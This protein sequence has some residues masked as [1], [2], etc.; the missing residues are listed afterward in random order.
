[1]SLVNALVKQASKLMNKPKEEGAL[2]SSVKERAETYVNKAKAPVANKN[3]SKPSTMIDVLIKRAEDTKAKISKNLLDKAPASKPALIHSDNKKAQLYSSS[4]DE[5]KKI[6]GPVAYEKYHKEQE[7]KVNKSILSDPVSFEKKYGTETYNERRE[8]IVG[9]KPAELSAMTPEQK[10]KSAILNIAEDF[11]SKLKAGWEK[12]SWVKKSLSGNALGNDFM[13][14]NGPKGA[15]DMSYEDLKK[16]YPKI[17][18]KKE[19]EYEKLQ[20]EVGYMA[21]MDQLLNKDL[22]RVVGEKRLGELETSSAVKSMPIDALNAMTLNTV[23]F[24]DIVNV[25]KDSYFK[26][27]VFYYKGFPVGEEMITQEGKDAKVATSTVASLIGSAPTY[28]GISK[29]LG[30]GVK[31]MAA[32]K[33]YKTASKAFNA[34]L[35][36]Q[37]KNPL[38]AEVVGYNAAEESIEMGIRKLSGQDYTFKDFLMGLGVG[39]F[40]GGWMVHFSNMKIGKADIEKVM[41]EAEKVYKE[42]GDLEKVMEVKMGNKTLGQMFGEQRF[43]YKKKPG[44]ATDTPEM[45]RAKVEAKSAADE[46]VIIRDKYVEYLKDSSG[47]GVNQG[48]L[49]KTKDGKVVNRTGRISNNPQWYRDF[50]A[51]KGRKPSNKELKVI[52]HDHLMNGIPGKGVDSDVPANDAFIRAHKYIQEQVAEYRRLE[53]VVTDQKPVVDE[54]ASTKKKAG[55]ASEIKE[56]AR[57]DAGRQP[58]LDISKTKEV[59]K[60]T[61]AESL[62]QMGQDKYLTLKKVQSREAKGKQLP[63]DV[64]VALNET[65]YHG[66]TETELD[67]FRNVEIRKI[68]D[69]LNATKLGLDSQKLSDRILLLEHAP[70]YNKKLGDGAAGITTK[71]A[72]AELETLKGTET[73]KQVRQAANLTRKLS[74]ALPKYLLDN[75]MISRKT[76]DSWKKDYPN[77]VSLQRILPEDADYGN[78]LGAGRGF[79]VRGQEVKAAKGSD[80]EVAGILDNTILNW[81]RSIMRVNKNKV[82]KSILGFTEKYPENGLFKTVKGEVKT[83]KTDKGRKTITVP[84]YGDDIITVKVDGKSKFI[85]VMDKRTAESLKNLGTRNVGKLQALFAP[86][87]RF[88]SSINTSMNPEFILTNFVKDLQ[89]GSLNLVSELGVKSAAKASKNVFHAQKGVWDAMAGKDSKWGNLYKELQ[90]EGGTTGFFQLRDREG[91]ERMIKDMQGDLN[92]SAIGRGVKGIKKIGKGINALNEI[93][94][95]GMRLSAYDAALKA[96]Y[97]KPRAAEVAKEATVNFN[98]S[99]EWGSAMNAFYAFSNAS[100]QGSFRTFKALKDPKTRM[101]LVSTIAGLSTSLNVWNDYI[102]EEGHEAI[103]DYEKET[104]WIIMLG[105]GKYVKIPAPWGWNVFKV[106]SDQMYGMVTGKKTGLGSLSNSVRALTNAYNPLGG[107]LSTLWVPTV[108]RPYSEARANKGWHGGEIAPKNFSDVKESLNYYDSTNPMFIKAAEFLSEISGGDGSKPGKIEYSPEKIEY[109]WKQYSGGIGRVMSNTA[110]TA[111]R[112]IEGEEQVIKDVPF[113][114]RFGGKVSLEKYNNSI[115]YDTLDKSSQEILDANEATAF[116]EAIAKQVADGVLTPEEADDKRNEMLNGQGN[117]V[118]IENVTNMLKD[119][120]LNREEAKGLLDILNEDGDISYS[121]SKA[122]LSEL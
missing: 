18:A 4:R 3:V 95:N 99:G 44:V 88:M 76:F 64:D 2:I 31:L 25:G 50:Y 93:V 36:F 82:S 22:K 115:I 120:D 17:I 5:F 37:K 66:K 96:G 51:E 40:I 61:R 62:K 68:T 113:L 104:N 116:A 56:D 19:E 73:Y 78:M 111:A 122:I 86:A 45:A 57:Y 103:P 27:G 112:G 119:A 47:K 60:L 34:F 106:A 26:K 83:I 41:A 39:G 80:L 74:N 42:T 65:L 29:A 1:M 58:K 11:Q 46:A 38:L 67:A 121:Q 108:L 33:Q 63:D 20:V 118:E 109:L 87:T 89:G 24:E 92:N 72:K 35:K 117:L 85:K 53:K 16:N 8:I 21:Y 70:D 105:D 91:V 110:I 32:A 54:I 48:F 59:P 98:K 15:M 23:N 10:K 6:Y 101:P 13:K 97:S 77:H 12:D 94:E 52:A 100:V 43:A 114:R 90:A 14:K 84:P 7:Q 9:K 107:D 69:E 30:A 28:V 81:E 79:D 55:Y 102:D 49:S 75:G 71:E